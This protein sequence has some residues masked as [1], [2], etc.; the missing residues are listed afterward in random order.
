MLEL[1]VRVGLQRREGGASDRLGVIT[2]FSFGELGA[3]SALSTRWRRW[4][5][6][7]V[8]VPLAVLATA[9]QASGQVSAGDLAKECAK[10]KV[11]A[12]PKVNA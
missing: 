12:A 10:V 3:A 4:F 9:G 7:A 2:V 1:L 5:A 11:R 8:V 6:L